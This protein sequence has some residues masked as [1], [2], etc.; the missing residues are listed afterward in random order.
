MQIIPNAILLLGVSPRNKFKVQKSKIKNPTLVPIIF[1]FFLIVLIVLGILFGPK[2]HPLRLSQNPA[3]TQFPSLTPTITPTPTL[4]PQQLAEIRRKQFEEMGRKYGPCRYVPILMYHHVLPADQAK[5]IGASNLNVPPDIFRQQIDYLIG[6][7]YQ[8]I[9]LDELLPMIAEGILPVKPVVLTF[10]DGY[11][12]FYDNVFP[13]LKEKNVKATSFVITQFAGGDRYLLWSQINELAG[14]GLVLI[15]DHTLNHPWLSKLDKSQETNQI[16]SAKNILAQNTGKIINLFAYP[17]G[18][19]NDNAKSVLKENG[20]L[21][22]VTTIPGTTQC[23][24]LPYDL[25]RIRV[26]GSSLSKYGL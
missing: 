20:F 2:G 9:G 23:V 26:G 18:S 6:K 25:Q 15:G 11:R 12:D 4:T 22:A 16:V 17:Y 13:V 19:G 5:N 7:G 14:S 8:I 24:G 10:D 21:G 1:F 3:V